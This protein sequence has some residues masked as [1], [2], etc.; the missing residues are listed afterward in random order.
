[1]A[2]PESQLVTWSHQGSITQSSNTYESIKAVLESAGAGY[3]GKQ[4]S[5]FL[6]GSYGNST[7]IYSESDV[8]IVIRLDSSWKRDLA[9]LEDFE[10][11]RYK[12]DHSTADYDYD[13]FKADAVAV[14]G[15]HFGHSVEV[16]NK[17]IKIN[18][19]GSR[20][21]AD[22]LVAGQYRRYLS[23]S[24]LTSQNYVEGIHF[25]DSSGR[26]FENYPKQHMANCT[27]KH[28]ATG[29][30]FKPVIRV[31]KNMKVRMVSEGMIPAGTAP[32]YFIEGLLYNVPD[33]KFG[34][35]Y[36]S[37]VVQSINWLLEADRTNFVCANKQQPLFDNSDLTWSMSD[38]DTYLNTLCDL[39]N[40]W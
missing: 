40:N 5:I 32:S 31:F 11:D 20:R 34:V 36:D 18:G 26:Q 22:V 37:S 29:K 7:N 23:Y 13:A 4:F 8:D 25:Y 38:C 9:R 6:Q 39:W 2:I 24:S 1:M 3:A 27:S 14:L 10:K 12:A 15:E 16:G 33:M 28:Q 17:A 19:N 30:W 21:D 35:K